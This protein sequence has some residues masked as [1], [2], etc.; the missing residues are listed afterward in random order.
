MTPYE[1]T[2]FVDKL[3][4]GNRYVVRST[5]QLEYQGNLPKGSHF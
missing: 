1:P 4:A 2:E 5:Q 3:V